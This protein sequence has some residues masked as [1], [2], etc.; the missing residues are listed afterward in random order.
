VL[1]V[2]VEKRPEFAVLQKKLAY[3]DKRITYQYL[4]WKKIQKKD[5]LYLQNGSKGY[6]DWLVGKI[7][8]A[9]VDEKVAEFAKLRHGTCLFFENGRYWTYSG[10]QGLVENIVAQK[11]NLKPTITPEE[12]GLVPWASKP[13]HEPRWYQ[14]KAVDL[15]CPL[16]GSRTHGAIEVGTGLGKTLIMAL[17]VK[18]IGLPTVIC[19]PTLSIASQALLDFQ[20]WFGAGK[21]GQ[22]FSG[23]KV[24]DRFI[25]IAVS[26]SLANVEKGD[27]HYNNLTTKKV[28]LVDE[29]H[30]APPESLST[31]VF[32][33]LSQCPY[34]YFLSG[35]VLRNDGL[36]LLLDG[37]TGEV[38][39]SMS[40]EQGIKEGFLSPLKFFQ[41]RI[42]SHRSGSHGDVL[43][44]NK[45]FLQQNTNIYKHASNLINRA[46][47]EKNRRALVLVDTVDQYRFLL[48]GGLN[49]P[50]RFAHG[51]LSKDNRDTVPED[52]WKLEP[53]DLVKEFDE[54]KFSV[55]VAT[56]C[57]S[58]GT[59]IKSADLLI[60]IVGL[61]SEIEIRQGIGRGTRL[62]PGKSDT[63][64]IDYDVYNKEVLTRHAMKRRK[65]FDSVYGTCKV[66]DAK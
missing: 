7:G 47:T 57:V 30:L 43:K 37:I 6:R 56:G 1:P 21:V 64:Y 63:V 38:V 54:G 20:K 8:R 3:E 2:G 10:L 49:V 55:L 15:L 29:T 35:T 14:S 27:K 16:D 31:V 22:F 59:D 66:M 9:A 48:D 62:F 52:Q 58:I 19:V 39:F 5:D 45:V 53:M 46:V 32:G 34:R 26:K 50:S 51:P 44:D 41:Y 11:A 25:T 24:S 36:Q 40:V 4:K 23:K 17:I 42:K 65:I 61:T 13:V 33:L 12:W 60:N 28:L 18:R